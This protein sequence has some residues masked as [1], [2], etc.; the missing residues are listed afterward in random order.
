MGV[1]RLG[2]SNP[3]TNTDTLIYTADY[4]FL[5]SV[6]ATNMTTST[7]LIDVWVAPSGTTQTSQ[8]TYY[9]Y[10]TDVPP[11]NTLET[12]KFALNIGDRVYVRATQNTSFN[13]S[14]LR[15]VDIQLATGV[16]SM[17]TTAPSNPINGQ[18]WVD[19]DGVAG[20][21]ISSL[22]GY[23]NQASSSTQVPYTVKGASGQTANLQEWQDSTGTVQAKVDSTGQLYSNQSP[24]ITTNN[25]YSAGKNKIINGDFG[26]W[27]RATSIASATAGAY[28]TVDRFKF[29]PTGG[30]TDAVSRQ[31]FTP[32]ATGITGYEPQYFI[33]NI[34]VAGG[35][36]STGTMVQHVEDVRTFANQ[37]FTFSFWAKADST[38]LI[39]AEIQQQFGT[40]G[41]SAVSVPL[42]LKTIGT[43]WQRYSF[44]GTL[45]SILG[46]TIGPDSFLEV[47]IWMEADTGSY[48]VR[49]SSIGHQS[50]TFDFWGVQ[51]EAGTVATNFVTATGNPQA[52]LAACQRYFQKIGNGG[53]A[54]YM[55]TVATVEGTTTLWGP[56]PLPVTMRTTPSM[57]AT[58]SGNTF[59]ILGYGNVSSSSI[60]LDAAQSAPNC[61][62]MGSN[63][64]SGMTLYQ[65]RYIRN[66]NDSSGT[67]ISLS[68]EL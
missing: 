19:S 1:Q 7:S 10:Q 40:G 45:P 27:Q 54:Y 32:G 17:Q 42:G 9:A 65:S 50:G 14:G 6:I 2:L 13:I 60:Y 20:T 39:A 35:A 63:T 47:T 52:E 68:A 41:S 59:T 36:G 53:G 23:T 30:T 16:T 62:V 38:K 29:W 28:T 44:T 58:S 4:P 37:T 33:R 56:V 26:I 3:S 8:Y 66:L 31:S 46:K 48:N 67:Y 22:A 18:V 49:S 5:A 51:L 11:S 15:Q 43:T 64:L 12:H 61:I 55:Y 21:N 25:F 57:S 24:V 34:I